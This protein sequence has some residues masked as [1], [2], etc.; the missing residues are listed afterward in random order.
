MFTPPKLN[1][2]SI[3]LP[4][5]IISLK[6]DT[7]RRESL[8]NYFD[9]ELIENYFP[10]TDLREET[11][12]RIDLLCDSEQVLQNYQ[13]TLRGG[14]LG[15]I[16]S[17]QKAYQS[18]IEN[19][20]P[21]ALILEDDVLP[22]MNWEKSLTHI[23]KNLTLFSE[24]K[25]L[26]CHLGLT[27]YKTIEKKWILFK[28][29]F[30]TFFRDLWLTEPET[31]GIWLSHAYLITPLAAA[32]MLES[33]TP[34]RFLADDWSNFL[35]QNCFD[36]F[37]V[38]KPIFYQ[39]YTLTSNIQGSDGNKQYKMN[40]DRIACAFKNPTAQIRNFIPRILRFFKSLNLSNWIFISIKRD[41]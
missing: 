11:Q 35:S 28:D 37:L 26:I 20:I 12:R 18:I 33:N 25:S 9:Q 8:R 21:L 31:K 15:I 4:V 30:P 41:C 24:N 29:T 23:I 36:Y 39:N 5:Y 27:Y 32:R 40:R 3:K 16:Q 17:Q 13:R 34:I 22:N 6:D 38:S 2:G 10:A 1:L 7:H 14:E 19:N